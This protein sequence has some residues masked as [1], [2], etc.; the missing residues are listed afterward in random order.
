MDPSQSLTDLIVQRLPQYVPP[1]P[2]GIIYRP[3]LNMGDFQP[4][5]DQIADAGALAREHMERV[6]QEQVE[7]VRREMEQSH[8]ATFARGHGVQV[9]AAAAPSWRPTGA[10]AVNLD[11]PLQKMAY[12][13]PLFI[14]AHRWAQVG[15][16]PM[17]PAMPM[18]AMSGFDAAPAHGTVGPSPP[19]EFARELIPDE[20]L[21]EEYD[22]VQEML[23]EIQPLPPGM[24][25]GI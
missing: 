22:R 1:A 12:H 10:E 5:G 16:R 6:R 4:P 15:H 18:P 20:V 11:L 23:E 21:E 24:D 7:N 8:W 9:S 25:L 13:S 2:E 3:D 19:G 17:P 14:D